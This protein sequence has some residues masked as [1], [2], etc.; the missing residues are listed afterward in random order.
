MSLREEIQKQREQTLAKAPKDVIEVL[1]GTTKDLKEQ[2]IENNALGIGDQAVDFSLPNIHGEQVNLNQALAKG[3]VVL[4]IYRGGWC[5]YCNL[6]LHALQRVLPEIEATGAQ[7]IAIAPQLPD[8]SIESSEKHKLT[9]EVL[10]DVGNKVSREY[11]LVFTLPEALRPIYEMFNLDIPGYNG[12][13]SFEL[14]M[15]ATYVIKQNREIV[16]AFVDADYT[17]R[18]EPADIVSVLK[19]L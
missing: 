8:K 2:G 1:M 10:S 13:D 11:G 7:L 4:N 12:D 14:P 18:M 6:E 16:H 15:P 17:Q 3:P 9:F 19:N 5:P